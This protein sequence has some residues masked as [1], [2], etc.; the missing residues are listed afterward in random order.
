MLSVVPG[1]D[2][3]LQLKHV[4][5]QLRLV[6]DKGLGYGVLKYID[7]VYALQGTDPWEVE[8]N[9]LGQMDNMVKDED[10]S[11]LSGASESSGKAMS[12]S[13]PVR[14][15]L[16]VNSVVQDGELQVKWSFS[17]RHFTPDAIAEMS[18]AYL[19]NLENLIAH[20]ITVETP[21][22]TPSDYNLGEEITNEE[23]DEFLDADHHGAPR[24]LQ[25]ESMSRLS[26]LQ[27]G[28]LFHSLYD[29]H[30][31]AY[32]EQFTTVMT[33]VDP[34]IFAK[35]WD[36]LLRNHS[37]LR[38]A[39]YYDEF[40]IPVQ[41][42]YRDVKI[43]MNVVDCSGMSKE[44][45]EQFIHNYE[46]ADRLNSFDLTAAPLM[47]IYLIRLEENRY[48]LFWTYHHV[49]LDGWSLAV[50]MIELVRVYE[51]LITG[52]TA[53]SV[54][55][56][57]YED[58]IRYVERQDKEEA[59]AYWKKYLNGLDE[60]GLLPFISVTAD[61]TKGI[62]LY[63]NEKLHFDREATAEITRYVQRNHITVNTLMQGV[64]AYLL[65][66]Y[67]GNK[68]VVYGVIVSGRPDDLAG[69]EQRVGMYINT[70][71]LRA[72]TETL[73]SVSGWL[74]EIQADQISS[75]NYQYTTL[76]DIRRWSAVS[77]EL[78]DTLLVFENYPVDKALS[79]ESWKLET[80]D[81]SMN[82]QGNYPLGLI[83]GSGEVTNITFNYNSTLLDTTYA[84]A[85]AGHFKT[86]LLYIIAQE[87]ATLN[88]VEILS[89]AEKSKLL[90][91]SSGNSFA[92]P[93]DKTLTDIF[94]EQVIKLPSATA[95]IF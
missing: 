89:E 64:W 75:R 70:L 86:A 39:F 26:G 53:L 71:P 10:S 81:V 24:K 85:I 67:T 38:S 92:Y 16:S 80:E 34:E 49:L 36:Q 79:S 94:E 56:D 29:D 35:S 57:R 31:G 66:R 40:K 72:S 25:L 13:H 4:K 18:S 47:R 60:P 62:G 30:A 12:D 20:C 91:G 43:P 88:D 54:S 44:E 14:E 6:P 5:E 45:Q 50:L 87:N 59:T 7:K 3:G 69:V 37:I 15:L 73:Q 95:V 11:L 90:K 83:I 76:N 19:E 46:Q 23:L 84:A 74:Q 48:R 93:S 22:F 32:I 63:K 17:S 1:A 41:C 9:Y 51:Q 61:R 27:E 55:E 82:E 33:N 28:M 21:V 65:S 78:F 8:F 58:Y 52:K 68:D 77:G 42:V 2:A